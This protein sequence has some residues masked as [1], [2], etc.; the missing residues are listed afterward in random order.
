MKQNYQ[1]PIAC[2]HTL[3]T[4]DIVLF[5]KTILKDTSGE[6]VTNPDDIG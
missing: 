4:S 6:E 3:N 5:T 2:I 1:P